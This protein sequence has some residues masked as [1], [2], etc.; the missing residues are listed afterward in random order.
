[1]NATISYRPALILG[2]GAI[3]LVC[4]LSGIYFLG[5][6][7]GLG[8]K[9]QI[10][11]YFGFALSA[12]VVGTGLYLDF[13][14]ESLDKSFVFSLWCLPFAALAIWGGLWPAMQ[15][16]AYDGTAPI[17]LYTTQLRGEFNPPVSW[18]GTQYFKWFGA[19]VIL[20]GGYAWIIKKWRI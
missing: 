8:L 9:A 4:I 6:C 2:L 7:T 11:Y 3:L 16:W 17:W 10:F 5:S 14:E 15:Y 19:F 18:W 12:T 1:M 13:R 20:F